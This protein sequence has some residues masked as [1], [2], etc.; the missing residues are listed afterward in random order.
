MKPTVFVSSVI[1]GFAQERKAA[2]DGVTQAGAT[3]LLVENLPSVARSPRNVCLD[4]VET[5]DIYLVVVGERGGWT[6]PSGM[7]VTE[8]EYEHARKLGRPVV[9]F[10]REGTRDEHAQRLADKVS[11]YVDGR[12][13]STF[14]EPE[15]LAAE[16]ERTIRSLMPRFDL[17]M[18]DPETVQREATAAAPLDGEST[19]RVVVAPER[20][21]EVIDPVVLDDLGFVKGLYRIGHE[22]DLFSYE[23]GKETSVQGDGLEIVQQAGRSGSRPLVRLGLNSGGMLRLDLNV[24]GRIERGRPHD[25]INSM[26]II[27]EDVDNAARLAVAAMQALLDHLDPHKRY[28]HLLLQTALTGIGYRQWSREPSPKASYGMRMTNEETVLAFPD[29][30]RVARTELPG[31]SGRIVAML[32]RQLEE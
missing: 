2:A 19:L 28:E 20:V 3:P 11:D 21:G 17:P 7:K 13:R 15:D 9:A 5:A 16:V 14:R 31:S 23:H 32:R 1:E 22:V 12:F 6:A 10:I 4:L 30:R 25:M 24:T 8:E 27:E 26:A 18:R 29:P